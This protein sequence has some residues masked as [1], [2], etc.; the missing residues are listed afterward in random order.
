MGIAAMILG[1]VGVAMA[2]IPCVGV[3]ALI[4]APIGLILGIV[5]T[6]LKKKKHLPAGMSIAGIALNAAAIIFV[7]LWL[8]VFGAAAV[9]S[10]NAG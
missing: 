6:I 1:I 8:F 2:F 10:A 7:I 3:V 5:D 4:P 9:A